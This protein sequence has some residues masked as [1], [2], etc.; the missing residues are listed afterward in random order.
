VHTS[1]VTHTNEREK[2]FFESVQVMFDHDQHLSQNLSKNVE[3]RSNQE[4]LSAIG[5]NYCDSF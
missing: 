1:A 3:F 2:D 4:K 5:V